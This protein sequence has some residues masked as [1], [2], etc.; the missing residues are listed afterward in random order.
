MPK[1]EQHKLSNTL[2]AE[3]ETENW[4]ALMMREGPPRSTKAKYRLEAKEKF[5]I[6][7]RGFD[8][9]WVSAIKKAGAANEW[10]KPGRKS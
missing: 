3:T 8:R 7:T 9:A 1:S 2:R 6:G 4:L 10:S 5:N